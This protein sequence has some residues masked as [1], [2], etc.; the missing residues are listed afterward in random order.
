MRYGLEVHGGRA[1]P[2]ATTTEVS[3]S[4]EGG[5]S[6]TVTTTFEMDGSVIEF[7]GVVPFRAGDE[8]FVAGKRDKRGV[9]NA[10][11]V[12]LPR[13]GV[14]LGSS[15]GYWV[16]GAIVLAIGCVIL[17]VNVSGLY[18]RVGVAGRSERGLLDQSLP[19]L[20]GLLV[21]IIGAGVIRLGLM[22]DHARALVTRAAAMPFRQAGE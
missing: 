14:M 19:G 18:D 8:V 15:G 1:E 6:T 10:Y 17:A 13:Q 3:G 21:S 7:E 16:G 22:V 5:V 20:F 12:R 9:I 11:A 4:R 2:I